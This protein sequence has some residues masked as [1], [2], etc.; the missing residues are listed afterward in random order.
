MESMRIKMKLYRKRR[1]LVISVIFPDLHALPPNLHH[2]ML[3]KLL[4]GSFV[5][6]VVKHIFIVTISSFM[7]IFV[8]FFLV[9]IMIKEARKCQC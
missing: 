9:I 1:N 7:D 2:E 4:Q 8:P 5:M 6:I 3:C